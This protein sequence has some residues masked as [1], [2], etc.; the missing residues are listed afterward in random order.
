MPRPNWRLSRGL[1]GDSIKGLFITDF[2]GT[3]LR[4]DGTLAQ[5]DLDALGSLRMRGIKTAVATGRSLYSF[6]DSPGADLPVDYIIFTT[7]AGVVT[8][9]ITAFVGM[10]MAVVNQVYT[11]VIKYPHKLFA[12][13]LLRLVYAKSVDIRVVI[14][15]L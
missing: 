8:Q 3:L 4:S 5:C 10:G 14:G 15:T 13:I 1:L 11:V 7:G 2:D 12:H 9:I 6:I